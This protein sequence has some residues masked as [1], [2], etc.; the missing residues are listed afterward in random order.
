[1]A[2]INAYFDESGTDGQLGITI[3]AGFV[4]TEAQWTKVEQSWEAVRDTFGFKAFHVVECFEG[5][6]EF[7]HLGDLRHDLI[8]KISR[9]L[10][11]S[12]VRA[13]FSGVVDEDWRRVTA[14]EHQFRARFPKPLDLC[15]EDVV[16]QMREIGQANPHH[17]RPALVFAHQPEYH[18]RMAEVARVYSQSPWHSTY[19]GR[20]TFSTPQQL[21]PLQA[22]DFISH[23]MRVYIDRVE[24]G[25]PITLRDRGMR[26][27][28]ANATPKGTIGHWFTEEG[29][30]LTLDRFKNTGQI[31]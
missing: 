18:E 14:G 15:F 4:G 21:I 7:A 12:G 13:L 9:I 19:L 16:L 25:P 8:F 6:G 24:Y 5:V 23:E 3:L 26:Q 17:D 30:R 28:L 27:I 11:E 10:G 31:W 29:L 1:M 22:A 20:I 2:L